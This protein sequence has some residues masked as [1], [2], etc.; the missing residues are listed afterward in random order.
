MVSSR[1]TPLMAFSIGLV[2]CSVTSD[3]PAPG[4]GV[5]TVMTG[6]SMSGRSSCLRL[7]Q[8]EAPAMNRA[9]ANRSVTL[10][11][12]RARRLRRLT[13]VSP[14]SGSRGGWS[15]WMWRTGGSSRPRRLGRWPGRGSP[16]TARRWRAP[17]RRGA[18]SRS[19]SWR[20]LSSRKRSRSA[21][22]SGVAVTTTWRRSS[23]SVCRSSRPSST[24]R[25]A[26]SLADD[27]PIPRRAASSDMRRRPAA[28]HDVQDLGLG[29]RDADLGELRGVAADQ[30]VHHPLV[31]V[32]DPLDVGASPGVRCSRQMECSVTPYSSVGPHYI[33]SCPGER[34][35]VP[36]AR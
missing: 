11:L 22:A 25:S 24:S 19:R 9:A 8:A 31:A 2:T 16:W 7:P 3:E 35:P 32:E 28:D 5:T 33:A 14:T 21:S 1:G 23:A 10:R 26:S 20:R 15:V 13:S 12:L 4:Y 30:P 29:H 18:T 27:E 17:R 6:K 36:S 34:R